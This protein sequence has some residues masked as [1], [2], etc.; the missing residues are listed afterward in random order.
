MKVF[1]T[2]A[3]GFVGAEVVRHLHAAGHPARILARDPGAIPVRTLVSRYGAEVQAGDVLHPR[4]LEGALNGID[5]VVH[6]VGIISEV[7]QQTFENIHLRAT[8]HVVKAARQAGVTRFLHMSALG[9][10]PDAVSRYHQTKWAAEQVVRRSG[11]DYT[12]FRPSLIYGRRDEF[13]NLF[14]GIIRCSPIVP[15]V[16]S[17][18]A[19]FQPLPV[20]AVA[21]AF[22]SSLT[23]PRAVGQTYDLCGPELLTLP[24]MLDQILAVMSRRRFKLPIPSPLARGQALILEWV[25]P[26]LL[27]KPPPLNRDQLIM[28][29]EDNVGDARPANELF[30]LRPAP[31]REGIAKYLGGET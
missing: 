2:G 27:R 5:A 23:E 13:V 21:A 19:R 22:V 9:T 8:E 28:L 6:L 1:V 30:G 11:L 16:G 15:V 17:R 14:A 26:R 12:I 24:E 4:S 31:F 25:W 29:E 10:R 20:E 7:G 18:R 3:T